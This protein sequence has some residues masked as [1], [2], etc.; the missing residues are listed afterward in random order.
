MAKLSPPTERFFNFMIERESIRLSKL[1]G[2]PWPWTKDKILQ[3]YKFTNVKREHDRTSQLL[4]QEFY[5]PNFNAPREQLLLNCALARY[6]GTIAFMRAIGWQTS[7]QPA[8]IKDIVKQ[9][10]LRGE[11]VFTGAYIITTNGKS[12]PKQD[13]V[14]DHIITKLW[15]HR[16]LVCGRWSSWQAF[17]T[18]LMEVPGFGGSGFMA[19]EVTL[20]TRYTGFWAAG[21]PVDVNTWTPIGPGSQRGAARVLG[22]T[23]KSKATP[24]QTLATCLDLF[25]NRARYLPKDFITLELHDIQFQLCEFD[26]YERVRMKQGRPRSR[27]NPA[28]SQLEFPV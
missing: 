22:H 2:N 8:K 27:Y 26:K 14:I 1:A 9:K 6:F 10:A 13:T 25:R 24:E 21:T 15:G 11:K 3:E 19:K 20:D 12:G 18:E 4:I 5:K 17:I 7:Y 16:K 28:S 23:D